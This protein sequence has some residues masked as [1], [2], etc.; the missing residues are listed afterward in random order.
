LVVP[1]DAIEDLPGNDLVREGI[2]DLRAG[3]RTAAALLVTMAGPRL[4]RLGV[5][6]P[7]AGGEAAGH[8]LYELLSADDGHDPYRRYNAL[9]GRI[10]SFARALEHAAAG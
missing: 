4:R 2:A 1:S 9:V 3:H 6:V 7:G 8:G 5:E 10:V